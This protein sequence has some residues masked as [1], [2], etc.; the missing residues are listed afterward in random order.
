MTETEGELG[1]SEDED[2]ACVE[3][4]SRGAG[5][6]AL[7]G[8]EERKEDKPLREVRTP[9]AKLPV[10]LLNRLSSLDSQYQFITC[11]YTCFLDLTSGVLR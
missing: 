5:V 7:E 3:A 9:P 11:M 2:K 8:H 4:S 10:K 6:G 1:Q